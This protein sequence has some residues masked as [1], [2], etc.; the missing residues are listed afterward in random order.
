[1]KQSVVLHNSHLVLKS[2]SRHMKKTSSQEIASALHDMGKEL[3]SMKKE[4]EGYMA[5]LGDVKPEELSIPF[6]GGDE[7]GGSP[8]GGNENP[9][10]GPEGGAPEEGEEKGPEGKKHV[11][12]TPADAKKVLDE[13]CKDVQEVIDNLDGL[14]GTAQEEEKEASLKRFNDRYAGSLEKLASQA[15]KAINDAKA[16]LKHWSFILNNRNPIAAIKDSKLKQAAQ[17][18]QEV[19][20]FNRWL[21]KLTGKDVVATAVPPTGAEFSGDKWPKGH[22]DP[23]MVEDRTWHKQNDKFD[24]DKAFEDKRPNPAVDHRLDTVD[25]ARNEEPFVNATLTVKPD[26][27]RWSSYWS[28]VDTKSGKAVKASFVDIPKSVGPK[29]AATFNEFL[30]K[31]YGDRVV[32]H[33]MQN[34][35]ESLASALGA[36]LIEGKQVLAS[37]EAEARDPKIKDKAKVRKYYKDAYG[38]AAFAKG[39]TS[40]Q[41]QASEDEEG[42]DKEKKDEK[43]EEKEKTKKEAAEKGDMDVKYTP[44]KEHPKDANPGEQF[45]KSKDGAGKLTSKQED[46]EL[47][48]AKARRAVEVARKYASRGA[49]EFDKTPIL[50]KASELMQLD[51][52]TFAIKEATIEELPIVC[53]AALKEAHIPDAES[54]IVGNL[55]EGVRDQK[56]TVTA[57]D[58]DATVK[59]DA[60]IAKQASIVPQIQSQVPLGKLSVADSF[61]T[62]ENRLKAKGLDPMK[63]RLRMPY[64]RG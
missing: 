46:P 16:A 44:E 57:E 24:K 61:H 19:S 20:S 49:I 25:Y 29:N 17:T 40:S 59:S 64:K 62:I 21:T 36:E 26:S 58:V 3:A 2:R 27:E 14:Q 11:I 1:M 52:A 6:G 10:G 18:I 8:E 39:M 41:K 33:V 38:D 47:I 53:E 5:E 34:G 22:G 12:K 4:A 28:V 43:K 42:K 9:F 45:E 51:D 48:K 50:K 60:K 31:D 37:L 7:G 56:A 55:F 23:K 32:N 30:S 13:A 35:I 54:G 15:D 63:T